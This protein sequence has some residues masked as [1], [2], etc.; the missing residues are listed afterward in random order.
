ME[1]S[2]RYYHVSVFQMQSSKDKSF[3]MGL[4]DPGFHQAWCPTE[5]WHISNSIQK[6]G[7][8]KEGRFKEA[9]ANGGWGEEEDLR[10]LG[11]F[12]DQN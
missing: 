2:D 11:F 5:Q 8:C 10:V 1:D 9:G 4:S 6:G 7:S 12:A 3:L